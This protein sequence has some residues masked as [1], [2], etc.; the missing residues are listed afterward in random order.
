MSGTYRQLIRHFTLSQVHEEG[1]RSIGVVSCARQ[2]DAAPR[3]RARR[4][5]QGRT[6]VERSHPLFY[7]WGEI[8]R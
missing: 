3:M 6:M 8:I 5:L 7:S 4:V 2:A 1:P